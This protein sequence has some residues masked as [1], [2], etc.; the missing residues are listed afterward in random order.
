MRSIAYRQRDWRARTARLDC[1]WQWNAEASTKRST[2]PAQKGTGVREYLPRRSIP[3]IGRQ[4]RIAPVPHGGYH[5]RA[6][7]GLCTRTRRHN[8]TP[9]PTPTQTSATHARAQNVCHP[10]RAAH[11]GHARQAGR[12]GTACVCACALDGA[13]HGVGRQGSVAFAHKIH[14]VCL[15]ALLCDHL[16][17]RDLQ[18]RTVARTE[19]PSA[20]A[21]RRTDRRAAVARFT[22]P[23]P[24]QTTVAQKPGRPANMCA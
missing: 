5:R 24:Q 21:D 20:L 3:R 4:R 15:V 18:R 13:V 10:L 19:A 1:D 17:R 14:R 6:R 8:H 9:T 23:R 22:V 16:F 12:R 7:T 2:A 11:I